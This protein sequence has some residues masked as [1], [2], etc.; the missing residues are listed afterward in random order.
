MLIAAALS[1]GLNLGDLENMTIGGLVDFVIT[2][3]NSQLEDKDKKD[4]VRIAT[5]EDFDKF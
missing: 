5:Q 4:T 2:Y 3:N 1:R